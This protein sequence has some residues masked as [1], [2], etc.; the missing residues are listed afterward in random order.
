MLLFALWAVLVMG[1][2]AVAGYSH[3]R[4]RVRHNQYYECL[5]A[6]HREEGAT[7]AARHPDRPRVLPALTLVML[8]LLV[9]MSLAV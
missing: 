1:A 6:R 2:L 3:Y 9:P 5:Y 7:A 4:Y 8:T